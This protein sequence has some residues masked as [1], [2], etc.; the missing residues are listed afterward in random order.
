MCESLFDG[1]VLAGVN[2]TVRV[3]RDVKSMPGLAVV[4]HVPVGPS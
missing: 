3:L 2:P 1:T 4:E